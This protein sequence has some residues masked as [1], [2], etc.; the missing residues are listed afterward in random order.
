MFE[1]DDLVGTWLVLK[2]EASA[3]TENVE[4]DWSFETEGTMTF[5]IDGTGANDYKMTYRGQSDVKQGAFKWRR[6]PDALLLRENQSEIKFEVVTA[7]P[8]YQ[9]LM[10]KFVESNGTLS[11]VYALERQ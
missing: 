9:E 6:L 7:R 4:V 10:V 3:I 5:G 1:G 8:N 2:A 11:I